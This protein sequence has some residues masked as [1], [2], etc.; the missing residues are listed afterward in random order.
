[1]CMK[2]SLGE[3]NPCGVIIVLKVYGG[4]LR[5]SWNFRSK[6]GFKW[7]Y[8]LMVDLFKIKI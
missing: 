6:E 1:M 8:S 7:I 3:L 4:D 2:L 5:L